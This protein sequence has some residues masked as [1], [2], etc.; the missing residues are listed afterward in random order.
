M[1]L[2][3]VRRAGS[4]NW[5]LRGSVRGVPVFES[6][7]TDSKKAAEEIRTRR[8]AE[9]LDASIHGKRAVGTFMQA[10]VI[11]L[12]AG[13]SPRF[14]GSYDEAAG[15]WDGLIGHFG[16]T[17]LSNIGQI[18]PEVEM[19]WGNGRVDVG[20]PARKVAF[21][22]GDTSVSR[23]LDILLSGWELA[24]LPYP[25]G[26]VES[27]TG[28]KIYWYRPNSFGHPALIDTLEKIREIETA[29]MQRCAEILDFTK[30]RVAPLR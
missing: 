21:E 28:A 30:P 18:E 5:Y 17:K 26:P 20:W 23:A 1:S 6:T 8:E 3:L 25:H 12:E 29:S 16:T 15:K 4:G 14:V 24:L 7:G 22:C 2:K 9:V 11:Y 27:W 10:A 19:E 13:G